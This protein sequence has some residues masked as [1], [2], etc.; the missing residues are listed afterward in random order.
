MEK[1]FKKSD[2]GLLGSEVEVGASKLAVD[3]GANE[4]TEAEKAE[5][6]MIDKALEE[7]AEN[8][9][10]EPFMKRMRRKYEEAEGSS[11]KGA[12]MGAKSFPDPGSSKAN[13][14]S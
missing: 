6:E 11:R 4:K 5:E 1:E 12:Q 8:E 14:E 3:I 9:P 10:K 2:V 13:P 7:A